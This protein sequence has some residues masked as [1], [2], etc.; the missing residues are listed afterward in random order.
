MRYGPGAVKVLVCCENEIVCDAVALACPA[1]H[2]ANLDTC[3][4]S[5]DAT[6]NDTCDA[7]QFCDTSTCTCRDIGG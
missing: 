4:C 1:T 6:C 2:D 7:S 3:S 5:C